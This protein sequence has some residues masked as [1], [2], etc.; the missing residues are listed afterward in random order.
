MFNKLFGKKQAPQEA[1]KINQE[2]TIQK[3][4]EQCANIEKRIKVVENKSAEMK[5][6][7]LARKKAGDQRGALQALKQSK[8]Y[9]KELAKLDGQQL[10]LENQ[11]N[12]IESSTFDKGVISGISEGAKLMKQLNKEMNVDDIADL[13]EEMDDMMAE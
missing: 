2:E 10:M 1:P 7:A 9:E 3:L 11:K 8:M 6:V 13:R 5:K 12:M 4:T